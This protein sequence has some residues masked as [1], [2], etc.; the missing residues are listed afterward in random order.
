MCE[1]TAAALDADSKPVAPL[2]PQEYIRRIEIQL[3]MI[4]AMVAETRAEIERYKREHPS[5]QS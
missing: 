2:T 1:L 4:D 5:C 3:E